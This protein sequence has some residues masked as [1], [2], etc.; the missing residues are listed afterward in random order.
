MMA[1]LRQDVPVVH[2]KRGAPGARVAHRLPKRARIVIPARR[3]DR[4]FFS[5]ATRLLGTVADVASVVAN[6]VT[7]SLVIEHAGDFG[8]IAAFA[9]ESGLFELEDDA[10]EIVSPAL[11][12]LSLLSLLLTGFAAFELI[13]GNVGGKAA[14]ALWNSYRES[15]LL[16]T[17]L[18]G[19]G[20]Y[21]LSG[22]QGLGCAAP[23]LL[24]ALGARHMG[25]TDD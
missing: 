5:A 10:A 3:N 18:L 1:E 9:S 16:S 12:P 2:H 24:Y 20:V 7:A 11:R 19:M 15:P 25:K 23:L 17:I 13:P 4:A 22:G 14:D 8:A 21:G 6:P